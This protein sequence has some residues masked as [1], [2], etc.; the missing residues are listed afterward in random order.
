L[1]D[2]GK[3]KKKKAKKKFEGHKFDNIDSKS[4]DSIMK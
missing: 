4:Y 1:P 2:E 3:K